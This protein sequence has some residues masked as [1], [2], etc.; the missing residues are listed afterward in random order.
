[1]ERVIPVITTFDVGTTTRSI[2]SRLFEARRSARQICL[3][4]IVTL[5][6]VP[7]IGCGKTKEKEAATES[8]A[9]TPVLVEAAVRGAVDHL[10]ISDAVLY[11]INQANVT[12]KIASP[13]KRMLVNRGDHVRAG[14]LLA[15]LESADLAAAV[16]ESKSQ[17]DQ[18]QASLQNL[19]GATV[20]EDKTKAQADVQSA[21]QTF[22]AAKKLYDNRV[23]LQREGALAQKLVD[24]AKVAMVQAQSQLETAARHLQALNQVSQREAIRGAEAQVNAAKAHNESAV[25]QLSYAQLRSP[26]SGV[27]SD[28]SVYA[29]E[30][31]AAGTP[32]I[33]IVDISQIVA[34]ANVPVKEALAIQV[35]R[36][37]RITG[38]DGDIPGKVTVVSP[39][40]DPSTTSVEV[41][42]QA[43]NPGEKLKPGGTVRVA[44]IAETIQNTLI[45]QA[46]ALLNA[47]DGGQKV[48]VITANGTQGVAH[49]R[50]VSVGIRQGDRVQILSG[51]QEGE[52]VVTQGGLGLEDKAKVTIQQPKPEDDDDDAAADEAKPADAKKD[53]AKKD[54]SKKDGKKP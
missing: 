40:V 21:Q 25:A 41:W 51:L 48:M 29:G 17:Y 54:D 35:G 2:L 28:R 42:V 39:S 11:P 26:I 43:A 16:S 15:E 36:P 23:A 1:M 49:E 37:A 5:V 34:R 53:G 27:V 33:S 10:V 12:A 18:Q 19:T 6:L 32:I 38:P 3:I 45:V 31:P 47:D 50:R 52:Q 24:D 8:E 14:Q 7:L 13:I 9:P 46:S 20:P 30:M 22:D 4:A 44:I